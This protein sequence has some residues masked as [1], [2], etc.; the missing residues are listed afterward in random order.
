MA[1]RTLG[2]NMDRARDAAWREYGKRNYAWIVGWQ[3]AKVVLPAA[4]VVVPVG[5]GILWVVRHVGSLSAPS[6]PV[7]AGPLPWLLL[8]IS[9]ALVAALLTWRWLNPLRGT[10]LLV[11]GVPVSILLFALSILWIRTA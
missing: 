10:A 6:S 11:V 5:L 9:V 7:S 3:F 4:L 2:E 1:R 8:G